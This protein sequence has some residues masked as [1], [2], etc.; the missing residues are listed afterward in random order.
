MSSSPHQLG[1]EHPP[2]ATELLNV[3]DLRIDFLT[4]DGELHAVRSVSFEVRCGEIVALVGESGCG[5]SATA[6]AILR[7]IPPPGRI[8]AGRILFEG[9]DLL[10]LDDAQIRGVRGRRISMVFQDP[11]SSLNPVQPVGKQ[12]AECLVQHR[13]ATKSQ[14]M[15]RAIDLLRDVRIAD[16]EHRARDYPHQFSGGMRQRVMIAI[17]MACK[18]RLIIADEPTT[19]LDVTVQA[20]IIELLCAAVRDHDTALLLITHN[21]AVVARYADRVNVMYAGRIVESAD[22]DDLFARPSH[23]YTLG[24]LR[25]VPT[26][27]RSCDAELVP[28]SGQPIDPLRVPYGC[29]FHP[30]C[31]SAMDIC[32]TEVPPDFEPT[33]GHRFACWLG[34]A[35][36]V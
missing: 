4:R 3:R 34:Q 15:A 35:A 14:A 23:P 16:P 20:Q 6:N 24:L 29:A 12:I 11:M 13:M 9:Q 31:P 7:L 19:S 27:G 25:S 21:L 36:H 28:I 8:T 17:A 5:K 22:A 18:P 33:P 10:A 26:L 32:R 2:A 1:S 30:R